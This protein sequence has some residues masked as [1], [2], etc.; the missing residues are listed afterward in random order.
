M[1][2]AKLR[3]QTELQKCC[4][5]AS[6][7]LQVAKKALRRDEAEAPLTKEEKKTVEN[8]ERIMKVY[9]HYRSSG[10]RKAFLHDALQMNFEVSTM[11]PET[12]L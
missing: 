7:L 8:F 3:R 11:R 2:A 6:N 12:K 4:T 5:V 9:N 10:E 1:K